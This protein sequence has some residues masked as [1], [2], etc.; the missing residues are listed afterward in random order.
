[1]SIVKEED[2]AGKP[3]LLSGVIVPVKQEESPAA[4]SST[5]VSVSSVARSNSMVSVG[6]SVATTLL[7][8]DVGGVDM[9]KRIEDHQRAI[10]SYV[11]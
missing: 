1:M 6:S 8:I 4:S 5:I 3:S 7:D 10:S 9:F 11:S 2:V